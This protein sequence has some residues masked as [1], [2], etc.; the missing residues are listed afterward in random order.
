M[1]G[2]RNRKLIR[3]HKAIEH[4]AIMIRPMQARKEL[5]KQMLISL[6][7]LEAKMNSLEYLTITTRPIKQ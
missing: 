2:R 3:K 5:L 1:N 4:V 7:S 6:N